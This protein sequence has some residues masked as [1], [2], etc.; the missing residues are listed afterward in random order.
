MQNVV[1]PSV[2]AFVSYSIQM[3]SDPW[4]QYIRIPK[5]LEIVSREVIED[6]VIL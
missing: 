5:Y 2:D 1:L 4:Q 6:N 3:G